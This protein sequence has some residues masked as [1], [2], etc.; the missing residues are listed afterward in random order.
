M[1]GGKR[2]APLSSSGSELDLATDHCCLYTFDKA[3]PTAQGAVG[4]WAYFS[5]AMSGAGSDGSPEGRTGYATG[6][7][8]A[9]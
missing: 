4:P 3:A 8:C 2:A 5:K 7:R 9:L 6:W 1:V